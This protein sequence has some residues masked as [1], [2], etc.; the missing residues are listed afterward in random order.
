MTNMVARRRTYL[1]LLASTSTAL[2]GCLSLNQGSCPTLGELFV[3]LPATV[4]DDETI[5]PPSDDLKEVEEIETALSQARR[6][7]EPGMEDELEGEPR[8]LATVSSEAMADDG[9]VEA[10]LGYGTETYVEETVDDETVV[11][12]LTYV[13]TVC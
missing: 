11:F 5:D 4:P 13:E 12:E 6:A 9:A 1:G 7:Y 10:A 3:H 2:A 8:R